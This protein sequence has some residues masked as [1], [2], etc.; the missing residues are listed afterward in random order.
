MLNNTQQIL[1]IGVGGLDA[2]LIPISLDARAR[3]RAVAASRE[4]DLSGC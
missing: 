3:W 4:S 1:R 2:I